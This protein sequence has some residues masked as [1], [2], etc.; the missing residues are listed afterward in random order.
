MHNPREGSLD[1]A[2]P[3]L[4]RRFN[5]SFHSVELISC[6]TFFPLCLWWIPPAWRFLCSVLMLPGKIVGLMRFSIPWWCYADLA[7]LDRSPSPRRLSL[8]Q[9]ERG[10][11]LR[12]ARRRENEFLGE[13]LR[14]CLSIQLRASN[15]FAIRA[16]SV[17]IEWLKLILFPIFSLIKWNGHLSFG[18]K[19]YILFTNL[20]Q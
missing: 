7:H 19:K 16:V 6:N 20:I 18:K 10:G 4:Y 17:R 3:F 5:S 14:L 9:R 2:K 8:L 13:K 15:L 1:P 12:E 11:R